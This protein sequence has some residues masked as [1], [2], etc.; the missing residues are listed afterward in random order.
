MLTIVKQDFLNI[1]KNKP[2]MVYL[3]VYPV[4]LILVS[5]LVFDF[6]FN[7]TL[8][9]SYDYYGVT[10][11]IYLSL[12]TVIILP[13]MFFG[14]SVKNANFRIIYSPIS[15]WKIYVSKLFV[16]ITMSYTIFS[17]Y[18]L[19][20]NSLGLVNYGG[21]QVVYILILEFLLITCSILFGGAFCVLVG[22]EDLVTKTLNLVV[23]VVAIASG[24]F[25][26]L[27]ILGDEIE[28]TTQMIPIAQVTRTYFSIIYDSN[29]SEFNVTVTT[30]ILLSIIFLIIIHI[31][32]Y[33]E[34]FGEAK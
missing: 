22:N 12:A 1:L 6:M 31:K 24:L 32:Y 9:N 23:N 20:F 29:L 4:V 15:R 19:L 11:L 2:I 5:G 21:N 34:K 8:L 13:E 18:I 14:T 10:L 28:K 26:S 30:L 3:I 27:H 17:F 33:P 7:D 25:F 16:S